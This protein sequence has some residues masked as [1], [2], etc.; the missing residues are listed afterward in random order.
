LII[1][2][3]RKMGGIQGVLKQ[4]ADKIHQ[5]FNEDQ[6]EACRQIFL[7]LTEPGEGTEDTRRRARL[8]ELPTDENS[9]CVLEK[10]TKTRLVSSGESEQG[11]ESIIEISHEALIRGWPQLQTWIEADRQALRT[12]HRLS[13]DTHEWLKYNKDPGYLYIK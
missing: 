8:S 4:R 12:Q 2:E 13:E 6:Q 9:R 3:Y 1:G 7:R 11:A 5:A 10:L